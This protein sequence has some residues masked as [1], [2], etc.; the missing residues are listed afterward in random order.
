[1]RDV[2]FH[3]SA[4]HRVKKAENRGESNIAEIKFPDF[5]RSARF[6]GRLMKKNEDVARI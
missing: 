3:T 2:I 1:M 5:H 6:F 4:P